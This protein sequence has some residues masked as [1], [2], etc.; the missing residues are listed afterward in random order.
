MASNPPD[1]ESS[2]VDFLGDVDMFDEAPRDSFNL[3]PVDGPWKFTPPK[4]VSGLRI[5]AVA[6][7]VCALLA[8]AALSL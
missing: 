4:G 8:V 7:I 1:E 5:L 6:I 2:Q 3:E